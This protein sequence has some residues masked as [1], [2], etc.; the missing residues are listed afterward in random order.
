MS[1]LISITGAGPGDPELLTIK[2]QKRLSC[3]DVVLYDALPGDAILQIAPKNALF[4]Y[5]GKIACDGQ[6]QQ[7]RQEIINLSI[8]EMACKGKRIVRLKGG[9]PM[10][11]G[12]GAEEIRFCKEQGLN[13]EVIPGITAAMAASAEFEIPLTER[14]YSS[15]VL[16]YTGCMTN[17]RFANLKSVIEVLKS[18]STVSVYMGLKNLIDFTE[19]LMKSGIP[20]DMHIN[21]LSKVSQPGSE[22]LCGNLSTISDLIRVLRPQTPAI[23][24]IGRYAKE[25]CA[26]S[27]IQHQP[28]TGLSQLSSDKIILTA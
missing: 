25:I 22:S 21:I 8:L 3:A 4:I 7:V 14:S 18:G 9:D 13:Y 1:H 28:E 15:M 12:R 20:G 5:A 27:K 10:I 17:G 16:L 6:N 24:L 19:A 26:H 2:A 23:V 11:F